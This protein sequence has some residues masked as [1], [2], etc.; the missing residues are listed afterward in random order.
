MRRSMTFAALLLALLVATT[1]LA[2]DVISTFIGGGPNGIPALDA[3]LYQPYGT[4]VDASATFT[5]PPGASIAYL[6]KHGRNHNGCRRQWRPGL[7]R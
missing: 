6:S 3:F 2:Q 4:A 5:S 1:G 7:Q